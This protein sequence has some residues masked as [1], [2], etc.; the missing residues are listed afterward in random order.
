MQI[1]FVGLGNMGRGIALNLLRTGHDLVVFDV[2]ADACAELVRAGARP[3]S[4]LR[5]LAALS[6]VVFTSLPTPA[7]VESVCWGEDGL[8]AGLAAGSTWFDLSTNS[9]HVVRRLHEQ[10]AQQDVSFLDAPISG[11]PTGAAKGRLAVWVGGSE[12]RFTE[13]SP[14]LDVIG[15]QSRYV[16]PIGAGTI[17][18][19]V[20]NM[21]STAIKAV[22]AEALTM[23]VKAGLEPLAL[24]SAIREGAAGRSRSFDNITRFLEGNL[25]SASFRLELMRKDIDLALQMGHDVG[26]PMRLCRLVGEDVTEA[27][28]LGWADRDSQSIMELQ[29]RRAG[30]APFSLTKEQI[31]EVIEPA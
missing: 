25:D 11:G 27:L 20:H 30:L 17:S 31:A 3:A 16:G 14:V 15:D 1:G 13:F 18:K 23:G 28:S 12:E 19:L 4:S 2:S 26:V 10:L 24:W 9:V 22:V 8:A 29:L 5:E 7:I 21:A 6:D